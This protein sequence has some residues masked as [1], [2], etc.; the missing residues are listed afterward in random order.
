[1]M[2]NADAKQGTAGQPASAALPFPERILPIQEIL[3]PH[4]A[5]SRRPAV[6]LGDRLAL[7]IALGCYKMYVDT[8]DKAISVHLL[9]EG[10]WEPWI[11]EFLKRL[12]RPGMNVADIGANMGFYSLLLADRVGP[13]GRLWAFEPDP[14]NFRLLEWN[15]N[16]NG[17]TSRSKALRIAAFDRHARVRLSQETTNLGNHSVIPEGAAAPG[18][19]LTVDAAPLDDCIAA[20]LD[21]MKIDAEGSEPFIWDGM[22]RLLAES[23]NVR[24]VMEFDAGFIASKGRDPLA[25]LARIRA[26]GFSIARIREDAGLERAPDTELIGGSLTMLY[27]SRG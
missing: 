8:R 4:G 27:L 20:P 3:G 11:T 6:Y 19:F 26:D 12:A 23:P 1:M 14:Q 25:F 9:T 13:A 15:L 24:I 16:A 17:L 18:A 2:P 22:S 7:T 10:R 5:Q 21:L